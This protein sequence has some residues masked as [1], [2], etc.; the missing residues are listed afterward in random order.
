MVILK[1]EIFSF[2]YLN[3]NSCTLNENKLN[4]SFQDPLE[5]SFKPSNPALDFDKFLILF[6]IICIATN[7]M[8]EEVLDSIFFESKYKTPK[9]KK[10]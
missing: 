5:I 10:K 1:V 4:K 9:F 8:N 6:E 7:E 2:D 3:S